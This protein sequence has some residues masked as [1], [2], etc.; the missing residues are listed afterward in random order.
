MGASRRRIFGERSW[1]RDGEFE[2]SGQEMRWGVHGDGVELLHGPC[3]TWRCWQADGGS[4]I[5]GC[6][7]PQVR[8]WIIKGDRKMGRDRLLY[9][10]WGYRRWRCRL[11]LSKRKE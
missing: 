6:E 10:Q 1:V 9:R 3:K 8:E 4:N 2:F 5:E 11:R 7:K